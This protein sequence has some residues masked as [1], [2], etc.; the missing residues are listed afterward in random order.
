MVKIH[1]HL[2]VFAVVVG[3]TATVIALNLNLPQFQT[4]SIT[5]ASGTPA[6][7][8][9]VTQSEPLSV[10]GPLT[11]WPLVTLEARVTD[12]ALQVDSFEFRLD[13]SYVAAGIQGIALYIDGTQVGTPV[14]PDDQRMV[15]FPL[16]T[17]DLAQGTHTFVAK[18]TTTNALGN[19]QL[20][21]SFDPY[22]GFATNDGRVVHMQLPYSSAALNVVDHGTLGIFARGMSDAKQLYLYGQAE[23]FRIQSMTFEASQK[24]PLGTRIDM[25]Q[26]K[27]FLAT[28]QFIGTKAEMSLAD[29]SVLALRDKNTLLSVIVTPALSNLTMITLTNVTALGITSQTSQTSSPALQLLP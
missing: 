26:G 24:V 13:G 18:I 10:V 14:L 7:V 11:L 25:F 9:L 21:A 19:A 8:R 5:Q 15:R 2:S 23:D 4:I 17:V 22:T 27:Q 16:E 12:Q 28:A 20:Q 1:H 6:T 29:L 3:V